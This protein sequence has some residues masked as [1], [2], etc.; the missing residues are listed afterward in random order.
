MP[1]VI[2]GNQVPISA[3]PVNMNGPIYAPLRLV[4]EA[5]GGTATWD[6]A[7]NTVTANYGGHSA[8]IPAGSAVI[9]VDGQQQQ[10]S[11]APFYRDNH[12]WVP[13]EFFEAF[14]TPA[15]YDGGTN[16][17]NINA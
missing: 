11:V 1:Y 14:G 10:L 7:T 17:I 4:I 3:E 6:Q 16:T 9:T 2:N 5:M 15:Y 8:Q 13:I 12:T